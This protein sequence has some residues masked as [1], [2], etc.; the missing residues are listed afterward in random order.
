MP[1]VPG[2]LVS[3]VAVAAQCVEKVPGVLRLDAEVGG[4]EPLEN[5][6]DAVDVVDVRPIDRLEVLLCQGATDTAVVVGS[7]RTR[8][9]ALVLKRGTDPADGAAC[10]QVTKQAASG[11]ADQLGPA[12]LPPPPMA[13]A[14]ADRGRPAAGPRCP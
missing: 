12:H 13:A 1:D 4:D 14:A 6:Q 9:E 10:H 8:D 2:V 11:A 5:P 3:D 7:V